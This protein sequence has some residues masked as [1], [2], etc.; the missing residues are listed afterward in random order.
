MSRVRAGTDTMKP[1][2]RGKDS[3]LAP[4]TIALAFVLTYSVLAAG[5]A[6]WSDIGWAPLTLV[7]IGGVR[8]AW[9]R[10]STSLA[11]VSVLEAVYDSL[12]T[13]LLLPGGSGWLAFAIAGV[14]A[15]LAGVPLLRGGR[16]HL[17]PAAA[18]AR[19]VVVCVVPTA[20]DVLVHLDA[21]SAA[22]PLGLWRHVE[23]MSS[24]VVGSST[25]P[26]LGISGGSVVMEAGV[27]VLLAGATLSALSANSWRLAVGIV[28]GLSA[29]Q[30]LYWLLAPEA[31]ASSA[32]V[33][34]S[35]A[36]LLVAFF[37]GQDPGSPLRR[38][39]RRFL[40]GLAVGALAALAF[41]IFAFVEALL[42]AVFVANLGVLALERLGPERP[43]EPATKP[44]ALSAAAAA[45]RG[46]LCLFCVAVVFVG[47]DLVVGL[48]AGGYDQP[49]GAKAAAVQG[50]PMSDAGPESVRWR[51]GLAGDLEFTES[52]IT[53]AQFAFCVAH[54][55]CAERHYEVHVLQPHCNLG[56]AGRE[57]HPMSCVSGE[58]ARAYC[59]WLGARLPTRSEWQVEA[60]N[61]ARTTYPWG[62]TAADCE[63]A[64]WAGNDEVAGCGGE[65]TRPVCSLAAGRSEAGLCDLVGNVS[66]WVIDDETGDMLALGGAWSTNLEAR[67]RADSELRLS[68][69][70]RGFGS[71]GMR[72]VRSPR[73]PHSEPLSGSPGDL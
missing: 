39:R 47:E 18:S 54:G 21:V 8:L 34:M 12:L 27:I 60:T 10:V 37:L 65:G 25:L 3:R 6:G 13:V 68:P 17:L 71:I 20:P 30:T 26:A 44:Q 2:S 14:V 64:V 49:P 62:D 69:L 63:R 50:T 24:V 73:S 45:R 29:A 41:R 23:F 72:C 42:L 22:T 56:R 1:V 66:E 51:R 19:L 9:A 53:V 48:S 40:A 11:R 28:A 7:A 59:G 38:T 70:F 58:G 33:A 5:G 4:Q 36:T 31:T 43:R 35:G 67:L 57:S 61:R 15:G 52:E 32:Y 55:P 46:L 16:R